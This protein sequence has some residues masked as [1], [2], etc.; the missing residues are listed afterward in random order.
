[1]FAIAIDSEYDLNIDMFKAL[2]EKEK[3]N[4]NRNWTR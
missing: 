1:M 2:E 3:I 4:T